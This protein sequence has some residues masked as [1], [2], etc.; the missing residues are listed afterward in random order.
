VT[1]SDYRAQL[2]R[3]TI[4]ELGLDNLSPVQI[5]M[6]SPGLDS[7]IS[8][9]VRIAGLVAR[10]GAVPSYGAQTDAA[11]AAGL[12]ENDIVGVLFA[13]VPVL[14]LPCVVA[15]APKLALALGYDSE[16]DL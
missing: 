6:E 12:T 10:G 3:L 2:R 5:A 14:G 16:Q 15:A 4:N 8:A 13:L 1:S 9:L 7:R 11:L